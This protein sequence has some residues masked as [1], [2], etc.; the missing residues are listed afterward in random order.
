MIVR[1][2][3]TDKILPSSMS[4]FEFLDKFIHGVDDKMVVVLTSKIVSLC[5][6]RAVLIEESD[7][8]KLAKHEAEY[9]LPAEESHY[10]HHFAIVHD[11]ILG[12]SGIDESNGNG[13]YILLP[14][15]PQTT[16]NNVRR[17]LSNK[18]KVKD[19]GVVIT[20]SWSI[21][22]RLGATGT[23]IGYSGFRAVNDY[24]G[25]ADLFGRPFKISQ[26]NIAEGL[27]SAAVLAMGEGAEQTPLAIIEDVPFIKFC[28]QDPSSEEL[29]NVRLSLEKDLFAPFLNNGKWQKGGRSKK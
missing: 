19:L 2:V 29:E 18:Y 6:G 1:P 15:D 11:T 16:A 23:C 24:R 3:K 14:E 8:N 22:L 7:K 10:H 13:Y 12:M 5:E 27:A 4:L 21:P 28:A 17:Y 20:D 25:Q 9:Y 26:A